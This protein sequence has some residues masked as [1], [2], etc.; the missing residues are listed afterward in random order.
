VLTEHTE[1]LKKIIET[2]KALYDEFDV[3][4]RDIKAEK[5]KRIRELTDPG[6]QN[7]YQLVSHLLMNTFILITDHAWGVEN[8]EQIQD[9]SNHVSHEHMALSENGDLSSYIEYKAIYD[10]E[11]RNPDELP[12][13]TGDIILVTV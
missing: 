10:F 4:R 8:E 6:G 11:S 13:K 1:Q 9:V 5:A 7:F 12:F 2:C 3:K